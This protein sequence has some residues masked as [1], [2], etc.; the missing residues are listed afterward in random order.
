LGCQAES[1]WW[2]TRIEP[3][4]SRLKFLGL[5]KLKQAFRY[6]IFL[7]SWV[8]CSRIFTYKHTFREEV[9]M[10]IIISK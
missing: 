8:V 2:I 3:A 4:A 7:S 9:L 1:M 6:H 5:A 10:D